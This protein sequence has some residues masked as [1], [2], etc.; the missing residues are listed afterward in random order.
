MDSHG[1]RVDF[2]AAHSHATRFNELPTLGTVGTGFHPCCL[3]E[4]TTVAFHIRMLP[5]VPAARR[6]REV[7]SGI[8]SIMEAKRLA[9]RPTTYRSAAARKLEREIAE[10]ISVR[11]LPISIGGPDFILQPSHQIPNP[12]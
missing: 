5:N 3:L 7:E 2:D 1:H 12:R 8:R 4:T 6:C 11:L 9:H 10:T